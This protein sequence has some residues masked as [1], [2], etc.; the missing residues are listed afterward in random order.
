MFHRRR[1]LL[2]VSVVAAFVS[3]AS[4]DVVQLGPAWQAMWDCSLD[5]SVDITLDEITDDTIY[6]QKS[7]EFTQGPGMGG[8]FPSIPIVFRQTAYSNF[9]RIVIRDE[10]ITNSTGVDWTDFHFELMDGGDA[11]FY[12]GPDFFF[13]TSPLDN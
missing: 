6:I 3:S 2:A 9:T 7:A 5:P 12:T 1:S 4:A 10:I 13:T 8:L 11:L